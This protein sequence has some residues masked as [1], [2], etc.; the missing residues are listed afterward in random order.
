MVHCKIL[1]SL[2]VSE[3]RE[4]NY[5]FVLIMSFYDKYLGVTNVIHREHTMLCKVDGTI[6][7]NK[8]KSN[9]VPRAFQW[10]SCGS[11]K[12][13]WKDGRW[14]YWKIE[15]TILL[16]NAGFGIAAVGTSRWTSLGISWGFW[17]QYRQWRTLMCTWVSFQN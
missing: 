7:M 9:F 17:N 16:L 12:F 8:N 15:R 11:F 10:N 3:V 2:L 5:Q 14:Q 6:L 4:G 13:E 1:W